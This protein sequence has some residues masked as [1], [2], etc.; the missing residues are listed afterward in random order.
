M[1]TIVPIII[2]VALAIGALALYPKNPDQMSYDDESMMEMEKESMMEM[3]KED[4]AMMMEEEKMMISDTIMDME[5]GSFANYEDVDISS[6]KGSIILDFSAT[7][8]PSCRTFKEDIEESLDDIPTGVHIVVVDY[9]TYT[10]LRKKYAV[11]MQHTFVQVDNEGN[12]IKKWSGG[13][14]LESVLKELN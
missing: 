4:D 14:S 8:C 7:W 6:L 13:T 5:K 12:M 9:D 2:L 1:K 11:Q 10:D 3:E